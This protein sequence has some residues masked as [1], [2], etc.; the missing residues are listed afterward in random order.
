MY[1]AINSVPN[2]FHI[3]DA[4]SRAD[5]DDDVRDDDDDGGVEKEK[6]IY[7]LALTR[8]STTGRYVNSMCSI[9][10]VQS[11]SS[12]SPAVVDLHVELDSLQNERPAG[13]AAGEEE[14]SREEQLRRERQR[15]RVEGITSF[16]LFGSHRALVPRGPSLYL[17]DLH[18]KKLV[19]ISELHDS[20]SA[21]RCDHAARCVTPETIGK[22][23]IDAKFSPDGT[24]VSFVCGGDIYVH[25]IAT[26]QQVRLTHS[27]R[28]PGITAGVAEYI[29]QEEFDRYTGY[30]WY[31]GSN[32]EDDGSGESRHQYRI[33]Y[34]E[35]DE[36]DVPIVKIAG[37]GF[38][39]GAEEFRFPRAGDVNA[40]STLKLV[41]FDED[42]FKIDRSESVSGAASIKCCKDWFQKYFPW[43]EYI[44][45]VG[46]CGLCICPSL[47]G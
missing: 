1:T 17:Y 31:H 16:Q 23:K 47:L 37:G 40:K 33:A 3:T 11:S 46:K 13:G 34:L 36:R 10:R 38:D 39:R 35:V 6:N 28:T 24:M 22:T 5:L 27:A 18:S 25:H 42:I 14:I 12:P 9:S 32:D 19:N 30:W 15:T 41:E 43:C 8:S 26:H 45:R 29:M 44:V 2:S 4:Q 20:L 7:C 21:E